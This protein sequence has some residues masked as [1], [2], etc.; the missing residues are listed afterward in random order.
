MGKLKSLLIE[1]EYLSLNGVSNDDIEAMLEESHYW[2]LV[3]G[4]AKWMIDNKSMAILDDIEK[5]Y[6]QMWRFQ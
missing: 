4:I 1:E 2:G 5:K 6:L 3:D